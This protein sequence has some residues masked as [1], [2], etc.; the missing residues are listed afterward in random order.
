M[1]CSC[2]DKNLTY[3]QIENQALNATYINT[4][5]QNNFINMRGKIIQDQLVYKI[6]V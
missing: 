5:I 4:M 1:S 2:K 6:K 3:Y